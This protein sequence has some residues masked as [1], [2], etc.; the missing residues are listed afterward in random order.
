MLVKET[1]SKFDNNPDLEEV[2]DITTPFKEYIVEYVGEALGKEEV[3][4]EMIVEV[5]SQEF[6]EFLMAVAEENFIRG[7]RQA[8]ADT[9]MG[10]A[11]AQEEKLGEP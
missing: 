1:I 2:V 7:Y 6:P 3:T 8:F 10:I 11:L 9:E 5:F 4:V